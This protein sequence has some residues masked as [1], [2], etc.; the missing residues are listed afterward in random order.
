MPVEQINPNNSGTITLGTV[1]GDYSCQI[2]DWQLLPVANTTTRPGTYCAPPTNVPGKSSWTLQF[3][4]L[5]DWTL[6]SGISQFTFDNDG[7]LV[8]FSFVPDVEGAPTI[9]GD[10]WIT[11]TAYGG[12]PAE[13]WVSTGTWNVDGVPV[14]TPAVP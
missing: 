10:V 9:S 6:G 7:E 1:P 13:A 4:F 2:T 11:A 5:Q 8:P 3:A 14:V 12:L